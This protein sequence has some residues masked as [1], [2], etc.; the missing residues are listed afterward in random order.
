MHIPKGVHCGL[1]PTPMGKDPFASRSKLWNT[2]QRFDFFPD[3]PFNTT[4][5][6][7]GTH[8][9]VF[10]LLKGNID[11]NRTYGAQSETLFP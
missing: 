2:A 3:G 6:T 5:N 7:Q 10:C 1:R 9:Y 8:L 11:E 4:S